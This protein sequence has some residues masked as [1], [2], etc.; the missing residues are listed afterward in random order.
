MEK[1]KKTT[2]ETGLKGLT[3]HI[4][5]TPLDPSPLDVSYRQDCY[6]H[7]TCRVLHVLPINKYIKHIFVLH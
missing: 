1:E 3:G 7:T 2:V 5:V 4:F 6:Q